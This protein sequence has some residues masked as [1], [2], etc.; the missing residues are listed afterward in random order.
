MP[1]AIALL[2]LCFLVLLFLFLRLSS[3]VRRLD[4]TR[5]LDPSTLM[6][7][8]YALEREMTNLVNHYLPLSC[9]AIRVPGI[10]GVEAAM[11]LRTVCVHGVDQPYCLD[12]KGGR[13][14]LLTVGKLN[15]DSV[16][17]FFRAELAARGIEAK[18]GWAYTRSADP[19]VRSTLRA[20]AE[21]ALAKVHGDSGAE[22][23]L[24]QY[25]QWPAD[26][27]SSVLMGSLRARR[28][29]TCLTRKE[30]AP[31][32]G[33]SDV[34]LRN[35]EAGRCA[36]PETA[37]RVVAALEAIE[38]AH[39]RINTLDEARRLDAERRA[40]ETPRALLVP[41]SALGAASGVSHLE[42]QTQE[43]QAEASQ[44]ARSE[45]PAETTPARE[46]NCQALAAAV[47]AEVPPLRS[48]PL[49]QKPEKP[50]LSLVNN[51]E[52]GNGRTRRK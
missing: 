51:K 26:D 50:S 15:P 52:P 14:L 27:S 40:S 19:A 49:A 37:A 43:R 16:A 28:E 48:V 44:P 18:V 20:E 39:A 29:A 6:G 33:I 7:T 12:L 36:L 30:F 32:A 11:T 42:R 22:V 5:I 24:V 2:S 23:A 10:R 38:L 1:V 4:K 3:K 45:N 46:A 34:D 41:D 17:D 21:R 31:L 13:F 47:V 8:A 35:L 25:E 9:A